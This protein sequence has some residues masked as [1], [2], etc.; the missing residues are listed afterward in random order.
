[1]DYGLEG[2]YFEGCNCRIICRCGLGGTY[3]DDACDVFTSRTM[4]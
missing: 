3:H 2:D 4:S 1:M